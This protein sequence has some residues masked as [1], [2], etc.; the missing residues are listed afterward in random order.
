MKARH[1]LPVVVTG[2]LAFAGSALY[3]RRQVYEP[4]WGGKTVS[5]WAAYCVHDG[6]NINHSTAQVALRQLGSNAV[7]T[8]LCLLSADESKW[9]DKGLWLG[10]LRG[11]NA[12]QCHYSAAWACAAIGPPARPALPLLI[13]MFERRDC[14]EDAQI[15]LMKIGPEGVQFLTNA[16]PSSEEPVRWSV[17][18][19]LRAT[20]TDPS[21]AAAALSRALD[22]PSPRVR[23]EAAWGLGMLQAD[24]PT[25]VPRLVRCLDDPNDRVKECAIQALG[26][27]GKSAAPAVPSLLEFSRTNAISMASTAWQALEKIDPD[28]AAQGASQN[29]TWRE[30]RKKANITY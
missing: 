14:V 12:K 15:A 11:L 29:A 5:Q 9:L 24:P 28:A 21:S 13:R 6:G 2:L 7:P 1:Y 20:T 18:Y 27:F 26:L 16:L 30:W 17:V 22:D 19:H 23:A 25:T 8:L 4:S 10:R 3:V